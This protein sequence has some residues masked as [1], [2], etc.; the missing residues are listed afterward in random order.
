MEI[1][2]KDQ[3]DL[4]SEK[5]GYLIRKNSPIFI[6]PTDTIYGIGCLADDDEAVK[7]VREIKERYS[8]PFSVIA[9]SKDWIIENCEVG[10]RE[11]QYIDKL[12]GPY[13]LILKLKNKN[14]VSPLVNDNRDTLGVR[15]PDHWVSDCVSK[16][17]KP[18]VT[19]SANKMGEDFM[20]SH[21][22]L[23]SSIKRNVEFMFYEGEKSGRPSKVID[24]TNE[25]VEVI[26]R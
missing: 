26:H 14:A 17:G 18:I 9:P 25:D 22:D 11:K 13:T 12:P 7:K 23:D 4:E 15:I 20:T 2:N 21:E 1:I 19:T 3:Y 10:E 6:H 8:R 5:Y 16:I 24:L